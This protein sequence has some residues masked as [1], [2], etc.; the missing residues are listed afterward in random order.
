[1]TCSPSLYRFLLVAGSY[2]II[3][4]RPSMST[5]ISLTFITFDE[6]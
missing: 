3:K 5:K 2:A 1:M 4:V 6:S